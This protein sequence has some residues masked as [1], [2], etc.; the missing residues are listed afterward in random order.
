MSQQVSSLSLCLV[1]E[2]S[3]SNLEEVIQSKREEK[4]VLD[5]EVRQTQHWPVPS[6]G[7]LGRREGRCSACEGCVPTS[8]PHLDTLHAPAS[9]G[10]QSCS[11][12]RGSTA[13][14][15]LQRLLSRSP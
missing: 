4:A 3:Q 8:R 10:G 12:T 11:K 2:Y 9:K 6:P 5:R 1:M 15:C 14:T 13:T 7:S